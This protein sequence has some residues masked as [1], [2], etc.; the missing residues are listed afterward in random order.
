MKTATV[1]VKHSE[2]RH[3]GLAHASVHHFA[4]D[5]TKGSDAMLWVASSDGVA[6]VEL[7]DIGHVNGLPFV[8]NLVLLVFL[9][10]A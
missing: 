8:V 5:G 2:K 10:I 6:D 1:R 9:K 7:V 3:A 4:G